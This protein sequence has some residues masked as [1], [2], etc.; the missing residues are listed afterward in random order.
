[1]VGKYLLRKKKIGTTFSD[2]T[3]TKPVDTKN[4]EGLGHVYPK[5]I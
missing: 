5:N 4:V 2:L 3:T 1:M